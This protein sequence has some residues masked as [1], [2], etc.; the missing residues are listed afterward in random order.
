MKILLYSRSGSFHTT[1]AVN[2][3]LDVLKDSGMDYALNREFALQAGELTGRNL[4]PERIYDSG[5]VGFE[6]ETIAVSY[7]GD[8]TFLECAKTLGLGGIPILGINSG[9]LGFLANVPVDGMKQAL[10]DLREGRFGVERRTLLEVEGDYPRGMEYP[11]AFNEFTVQRGG[12]GMIAVEAY[13]GDE[14]VATYWGDGVK[15]GRAHV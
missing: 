14:M 2:V 6:K 8:G 13:V 4:S 1:E 12:T 15:I 9:R 7:G 5:R 11:Y 3:L 10:G